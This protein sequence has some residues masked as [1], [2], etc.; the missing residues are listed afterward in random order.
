METKTIKK[1]DTDEILRLLPEN[2]INLSIEEQRVAIQ[3]YRSLSE[4]IP[5]SIEKLS[6][7]L[8]N[9]S[10]Y[11]ITKILESWTGIFYNK[12]K[13]LI[14]FWGIS[15]IRM[16][17]KL[18]I[19]N[20]KAYAW[21]A[22]DAIFI[23]ELINKNVIVDSICPVTKESISLTVTPEKIEAQNHEDIYVSFPEPDVAN[24]ME[25]IVE[26]FCHYIYFF[27]SKEAGEKWISECKGTYLLSLNEVQQLSKRKNHQQFADILN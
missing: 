3:I 7:L 19:E 25:N 21:C 20:Q 5:L 15:I 4:G 26:N 27:S 9:I 17:H 14:G 6:K 8:V 13:E 1:F 24:I 2:F 22:W 12:K 11:E 23:P 10:V 18:S 16:N